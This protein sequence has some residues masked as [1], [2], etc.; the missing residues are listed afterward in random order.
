MA[1][2]WW[3]AST[4]IGARVC[5]SA[6]S[7][8]SGWRGRGFW[9]V[10]HRAWTSASGRQPI[11]S[12]RSRSAPN[13]NPDTAPS[14]SGAT[15][16][17]AHR[18]PAPPSTAASSSPHSPATS[19]VGSQCASS[20]KAGMRCSGHSAP[21]R[22]LYQTARAKASR[23]AGRGRGRLQGRGQG[24]SAIRHRAPSQRRSWR[25]CRA[26]AGASRPRCRRA[27]G[28]RQVPDHGTHHR[29]RC[30]RSGGHPIRYGRSS[31]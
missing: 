17:C 11:R 28:R 20:A 5:Q 15:S 16:N 4:I 26:S 27:P 12:P 18:Q 25:P 22:A 24:G 1:R 31:L 23:M 14:A 13:T 6:T 10:T 30:A 29:G 9:R 19:A 2:R 21:S 8:A 3:S 7:G